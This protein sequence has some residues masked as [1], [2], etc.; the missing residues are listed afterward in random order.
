MVSKGGIYGDTGSPVHVARLSGSSTP[1]R[2]MHLAVK[3]EV[4]K[5]ACV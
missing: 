5:R 2:T 4:N 3:D 1:S